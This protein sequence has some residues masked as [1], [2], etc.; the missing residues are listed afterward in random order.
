[1]KYK[2]IIFDLDGTILDTLAD[3]NQ[4][5]NYALT[6]F[7]LTPVSL[8]VTKKC[9]GNGIRN[10]VYE[11]SNHSPLTDEILREFKD[12]Y[13]KHFNDFTKPYEGVS[14]LID[15][16]LNQNLI[17]G[18]YSN[19]IED[20]VVELCN[21]HFP[22]KFAFTFGEVE[23]RLRKPNPNFLNEIIKQYGL[24]N[25]DVL[26]IGDSEVDI[27]TCQNA[28]IAGIFVSYGFRSKTELVKLSS[29]VVDKPSEIINLLR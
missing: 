10:L 20:I 7:N 16:C 1:M 8:V 22:D 23:G 14:E 21:K 2:M 12:Y 15:Y 5:L 13:A 18:V 19:K 17:I 25:K 3:L 4:A 26:Y 6:K 27:K 28:S 24:T 29:Q 11:C 9:I